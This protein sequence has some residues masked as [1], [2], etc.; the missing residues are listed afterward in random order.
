MKVEKNQVWSTRDRNEFLVL[1]VVDLD[2]KTWVHYRNV[3]T[4]QEYSC[5]AESFE[6][7]FDLV[8]NHH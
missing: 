7:R 5:Y 8:V 3:K 2:N 4:G 6:S 1:E